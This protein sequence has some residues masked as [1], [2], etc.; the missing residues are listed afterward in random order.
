MN[1]LAHTCV[2]VENHIY[3]SDKTNHNNNNEKLT[4]IAMECGDDS[5][6][7]SKVDGRVTIFYFIPYV[8]YWNFFPLPRRTAC[9]LNPS[10]F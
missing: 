4:A 9:I 5:G 7:L 6:D 3:P 2:F 8:S 1:A 10:C